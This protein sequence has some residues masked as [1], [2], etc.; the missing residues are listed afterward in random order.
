MTK[1][2]R[3]LAT[4]KI[5]GYTEAEALAHCNKAFGEDN[6]YPPLYHEIEAQLTER[7]MAVSAK[8]PELVA[9]ID[10]RIAELRKLG[11]QNV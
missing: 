6:P 1:R 5:R 7:K 2:E 3:V 11:G 10:E 8:M 9:I 4:L